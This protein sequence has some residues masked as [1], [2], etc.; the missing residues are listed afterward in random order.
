M[1]QP[2]GGV[3]EPMASCSV[4]IAPTSTGSIPAALTSGMKIGVR[5][6]TT[7]IGSTNMQPT[8]KATEIAN[9]MV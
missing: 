8:K 3:Q 1:S 9:R 6:S 4:T 2:K 5:I 7:T